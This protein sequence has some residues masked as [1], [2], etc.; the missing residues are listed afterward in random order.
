MKDNSAFWD[1]SAIVPLCCQQSGSSALRQ[2][3]R[4]KPRMVVWWSAIIEAHSALARL[5]RDGVL[6]Q[7]DYDNAVKRLER[8][9]TTWREIT[10]SNKLRDVAKPLPKTYALRAMDAQQLAAALVWCWEK[11]KSRTFVGL[12][13]RLNAAAQQA[14]F[15]VVP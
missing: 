7:K 8:L 14:G 12:D 13:V 4:K 5:L 11:P 6:T 10:P 15:T 1:S 9:Q 2:I 3:L